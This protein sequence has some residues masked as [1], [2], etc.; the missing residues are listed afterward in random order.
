VSAD[1]FINLPYDKKSEPLFLAYIAGL[2]GFGLTP[3][4]TLELPD[5][6]RRLNRIFGLISKC[7]YSVHDLSRV[8]LDKTP[9]ATP[10]FNMPF[11]LGLAVAM[12]EWA[13]PKHCW[14]VFEKKNHRLAK[15]LSD[16]NGTEV[17]IHQDGAVG[18]LRALSNIFVR[19]EHQPT[20]ATLELLYRDLV[21]WVPTLKK[22]LRTR[23]LFEA[24]PFSDVVLYAQTCA[25]NRVPTLR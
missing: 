12:K 7:P 1:C 23:T 10:R 3:R 21:A 2:C 8:Q 18:V 24:R 17:H 4:A 16:L 22:N 15:S 5:S 19:T 20:V 13:N 25:K 9:P 14:Y 6:D 11:E